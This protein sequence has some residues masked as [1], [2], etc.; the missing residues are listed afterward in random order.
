MSAVALAPRCAPRTAYHEAGHAVAAIALGRR[1]LGIS[2]RFPGGGGICMYG[3]E[4]P[5]LA[6]PVADAT[7]EILICLAG[8]VAARKYTGKVSPESEWRDL[9]QACTLARTVDPNAGPEAVVGRLMPAAEDLVHPPERWQ[10]VVAL[11]EALLERGAL[12]RPNILTVVSEAMN[13]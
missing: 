11:A 1:V 6:D 3:A 7:A 4:Q 5:D 10:A 12:T 13:L 8:P 2:T 9:Q